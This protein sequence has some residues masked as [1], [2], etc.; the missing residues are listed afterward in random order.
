VTIQVDVWLRGTDL[1]TTQTIETVVRE[2]REWI[3]DDVRLML[4]GMLQAMYRAKHGP[5]LEASP[6]TLRGLSW[7]VNP[8][9]EGGVVVAIEIT[10]GAA[11]SGPFD[12]DQRTL[13]T[14]IGR[15][16]TPAPQDT[17]H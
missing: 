16:L 3:D 12:I 6:V 11:V 1:A 8:Y 17:V 5:G 9:D 13:E 2:P 4:E 7:I 10:L 15:V 14:M